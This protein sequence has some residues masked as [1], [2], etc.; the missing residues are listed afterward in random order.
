MILFNLL[1]IFA[2]FSF[3]GVAFRLSPV[4]LILTIF[5]TKRTRILSFIAVLAIVFDVILVGMM[6]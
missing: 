3:A 5:C 4:L 1:S 6:A 2:V